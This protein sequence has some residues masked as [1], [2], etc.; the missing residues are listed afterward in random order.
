MLVRPLR[1]GVFRHLGVYGLLCG[2][3]LLASIYCGQARRASASE[4]AQIGFP[5]DWSHEHV[6]FSK[7][8][9]PKVLAKIQEDPRLL[10]QRLRQNLASIQ[11]ST[12]TIRS[13]DS[14]SAHLEHLAAALNISYATTVHAAQ[15][16][17]TQPET[18]LLTASPIRGLQAVVMILGLAFAATFFRRGRWTS[19]L[20]TVLTIALFLILASCGG[21]GTSVPGSIGMPAETQTLGRDWGA[22]IGAMSAITPTNATSAAPMYPAKYTFNV[23][24]NP[25]CTSDYVVFPTGAKR[26]Q[27]RRHSYPFDHRIQ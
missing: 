18:S 19:T 26:Y 21:V 12:D 23:N 3:V 20:L 24:L 14:F 16:Q 7:P 6:V 13:R 17:R 11:A 4:P 5:W 27:R 8:T 15:S 10:H 22:N 1:I 2:L 25:N 9:D